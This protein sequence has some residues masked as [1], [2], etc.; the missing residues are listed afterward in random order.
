MYRVP[1][2]IALLLTFFAAHSYAAG[3]HWLRV[4][5]PH[6][7]MYTTGSEAQALDELHTF[8]QVR[9][10]FFQTEGAKSVG[11]APVRIIAFRSELE[12]RPYSPNGSA[13]AYYERARN[14]DYIVLQDIAPEHRAAAIHEY[15]HLILEHEG[16]KL[17]VWL[18]E[19]LAD[20]Y[21]TLEFDGKRAIV[22]APL[23][24]RLYAL[25]SERWLP[26]DTLFAAGQNSPEYNNRQLATVFYAESWALA[27]MLRF[28]ESY[29]PHF[30]E[31]LQA[32]GSGASAENA[33]G[34]AF[35]KTPAEVY[36]DLQACVQRHAM[37]TA[38]YDIGAGVSAV[39][40]EADE[41]SALEVKLLLAQMLA[42]NPWKASEGQRRLE[43]LSQEYPLN[44]D[45]EESLGYLAWQRR[46]PEEARARF[47]AAVADGSTDAQ[48]I[49][50][51]A[52]MEQS[53]GESDAD[54]LALLQKA[55]AIEPD[56]Y[57]TRLHVALL[58]VREKRFALA[59]SAFA[60]LKEIKPKDTYPV[61]MALAYMEFERNDPAGA[62]SYAERAAEHAERADERAAAL[63]LVAYASTAEPQAGV[64]ENDQGEF[65]P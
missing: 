29:A 51:L 23:D 52:A 53:A 37:N 55:F 26:L 63:K 49:G 10:F 34:I 48:M 47:A 64:T 42:S 8:E 56:D 58:A 59:D 4:S 44:P 65:G 9:N 38:V 22:G 43:I 7:E 36:R 50:Y 11:S 32:I 13:F 35:G 60:G 40:A 18:N 3:S 1:G 24:G 57:E 5:T 54:V 2:L 16:L 20:V 41:P 21:S 62:K 45:I 17:P 12:F 19:G 61:M 25:R 30:D 46:D 28:G 31:F 6:F 39:H 14:R 33:L 27:H 15:T